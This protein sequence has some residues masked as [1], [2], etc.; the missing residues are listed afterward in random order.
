MDALPTIWMLSSSGPGETSSQL[1]HLMIY[2]YVTMDYKHVISNC[3]IQSLSN[4]LTFQ[5]VV[6]PQSWHIDP[7]TSWPF[8]DSGHPF[9]R[10]AG[11]SIWSLVLTCKCVS[12]PSF[13]GVPWEQNII[14]GLNWTYSHKLALAILEWL[15]LHALCSLYVVKKLQKKNSTQ[16]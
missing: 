16:N 10:D 7:L 12:C 9:G 14:T 3:F 11:H 2:K 5:S 8:V 15:L 1:V 4:T 13:L 6:C